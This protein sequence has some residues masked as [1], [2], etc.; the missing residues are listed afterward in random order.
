MFG[1]YDYTII[2]L[3]IVYEILSYL[4]GKNIMLI[5]RYCYKTHLQNIS[6]EQL[7]TVLVAMFKVD[8]TAF[9][10][11]HEYIHEDLFRVITTKLEQSALETFI[12]GLV[13]WRYDH[14]VPTYRK[15]ISI[16]LER[17][18]ELGRSP[19]KQ[20][21]TSHMRY[22]AIDLIASY[23]VHEQY[24]LVRNA[25]L[26]KNK[27]LLYHALNDPFFRGNDCL[28]QVCV[29]LFDNNPRTIELVRNSNSAFH[30][31]IVSVDNLAFLFYKFT[32]SP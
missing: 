16:F 31:K 32:T 30:D 27:D 18:K 10:W 26:T 11:P 17:S 5:D 19:S 6:A 14:L 20:F 2:P 1:S 12:N 9:K 15:Y 13:I 28:R 7:D 4:P 23:V 8:K 25:I 22:I 24:N 3:E 29:G 21:V